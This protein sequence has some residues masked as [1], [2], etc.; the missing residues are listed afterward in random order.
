MSKWKWLSPVNLH[1]AHH[2][3]LTERSCFVELVE[4]EG[5]YFYILCG[6]VKPSFTFTITEAD[7]AGYS[8][9]TDQRSHETR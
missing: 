7:S 9:T 1:G 5:L 3:L 2:E 6:L 4:H 8:E